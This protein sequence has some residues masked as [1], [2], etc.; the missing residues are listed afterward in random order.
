MSRVSD[1]RLGALRDAYEG[2]MYFSTRA[3][4]MR[5]EEIASAVRELLAA[6]EKLR[7]MEPRPLRRGDE[8][9]VRDGDLV[10][11]ENPLGEII[12]SDADFSEEDGEERGNYIA[13][14]GSRIVRVPIPSAAAPPA[15]VKDGDFVF[16]SEAERQAHLSD[17]REAHDFMRKRG[18]LDETMR[19]LPAP[20]QQPEK[21][22]AFAVGDRVRVR[23]TN[24]TKVG[25]VDRLDSHDCTRVKFDG[26]P[27]PLWC[28]LDS[29]EPLP[30]EPAEKEKWPKT[31]HVPL[32]ERDPLDGSERFSFAEVRK[33]LRA[34]VETSCE[35]D[36]VRKAALALLGGGGA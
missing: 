18:G 19:G 35:V 6:R 13:R 7:E 5:H 32:V 23:T 34:I 17:V 24:G 16:A 4:V 12:W 27:A 33:A 26:E 28:A 1:E 29:I 2:D 11:G 8:W 20:P 15:D 25:T 9:T 30:A 22:R 14:A 36:T 31:M 21:A 10:A 3:P